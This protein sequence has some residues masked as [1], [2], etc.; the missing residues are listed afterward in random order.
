MVEYSHS[1][2]GVCINC[3]K[4]RGLN[5]KYST[6]EYSY[7]HVSGRLLSTSFLVP[8]C[9]DLH[10]SGTRTSRLGT[11]KLHNLCTYEHR[12]VLWPTEVLNYPILGPS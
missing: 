7:V 3:E 2:A 4:K 10:T 8:S 11:R 5:K 12:P 6:Y 9:V 1:P